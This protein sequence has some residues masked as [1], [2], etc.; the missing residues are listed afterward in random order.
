MTFFRQSPIKGRAER[1]Q[2]IHIDDRILIDGT[3]EKK[4]VE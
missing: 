1:E 2:G 3:V 4:L